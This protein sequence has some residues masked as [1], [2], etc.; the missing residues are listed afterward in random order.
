M[1]LSN[2]MRET[3]AV[4][5]FMAL[6]AC[7][8]G[9]FG[10]ERGSGVPA[11]EPSATPG[12]GTPANLS[13]RPARADICASGDGQLLHVPSPD[14][15]DQVIY[16]LM[17]DRFDDGD[18]SN[19]DQGYGEYDP[20][21][22]SHFSGGDLQ[23]IIDRLD[24]IRSLGATAIWITP[25]VYNQWWSTPYQATGWHGYW[26]VHF[27]EID[28]H[29]GALETYKRLSHELHCRGMYLVQDI[30]ANHVGNFFAYDGE[31]DP[32]DTARNFYLL[33]PDSHQPAPTQHPFSQIDRH[34]PE[35]F[36]AD[37]Y[38]WTPSVQDFSDPHQEHYYSLGHVNDINTENPQVIAAFKETYKYW[39]DEVGVDAFRLDT[40]MLAPLQF[41]NR[42]LHDDDGIYAHAR[43][44]GKV[45][46][47]TFGEVTGPSEPYADL[48]ERKVAGYLE[49]DG[50]PGPNSMLG[51]PLYYEISRVLA[52][53]AETASLAY[54]L[55]RFMEIYRDP[56]V[57]PNFVDNHDT[58]RFLAAG[59]PAAFRQALALVFTIPGIPIVYQGTEQG[60]PEARMAMFAGGYRNR[61]GSFDPD[62]DY[63]R[64]V[65]RLTALRAAHPVLTRGDLDILASEPNGPGVLAFRRESRSETAIVLFN[66]ADH[67]VL[68]NRLDVE[69]APLQ[70]LEVLFT[71]PAI[72]APITGADGRLSMRLAPRGVVVLRPIGESVLSGAPPADLDIVID[73]SGIDGNELTE[74]FELTGTVSRAGAALELILNG[75]MDRT[76]EFAADAQGDWRIAV[77]VRDLG[78]ASRFL[79]VYSAEADRLSERVNYTTRVTRAA[80]SAVVVDDPD[81]AYGPTG[82]YVIPQHSESARQREIESVRVRAAGRNLELVLTMAEITNPWLPPFGFDNVTFTTF[83]DLPD[84]V[85]ATALPLLD[86]DAPGAMDWDLAH[87]ARGWDSYTYRS[88]GSSAD[89]QGGKLGVSPRVSADRDNRTITFFYEGAALGVED[90]AGSRIFV[91]TWLSSAEGDYVDIRP[92]PSDW[93]FGGGGPGDPKILDEVL[94]EL[95]R[96]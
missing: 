47:L 60:L 21:L 91:T 17:I 20:A 34:N 35:H 38:H 23:G 16:M 49:T 42:F 40:V 26:A 36:A 66:S 9:D 63:F 57:I 92:E 67:S 8:P 52:Q 68:L 94:V 50:V 1:P 86:A 44:L 96:E 18:P 85:G 84:R 31:Y 48:G 3:V 77:P 71:E 15:R 75:N 30:V 10:P 93:F 81:D 82:Q 95:D 7:S 79:Q 12:T 58:A 55:E 76:T 65:Q 73:S 80:V 25:P 37:I 90:W 24:Y 13:G 74:D 83:F 14:W 72:D 6:A 4:T 56:F 45:H 62:S 46:F 88:S 61:G 22:A 53:G 87:F 28:P 19:N 78:E 2:P 33:E 51:Y 64:Y 27:Q 11:S 5:I 39:L 32:G 43:D 70:R 59:H 29:F 89:R 41:W 54:R 69:A